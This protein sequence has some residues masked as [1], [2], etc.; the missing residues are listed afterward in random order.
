MENAKVDWSKW[1]E[2]EKPRRARWG[3][4]REPE[5]EKGGGRA[6]DDD[7][8]GGWGKDRGV[9]YQEDEEDEEGT[10][11]ECGVGPRPKDRCT[12]AGTPVVRGSTSR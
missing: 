2:W 1:D 11:W 5:E 4:E 8:L 12:R 6:G 3:E 7:G 10:K 9:I